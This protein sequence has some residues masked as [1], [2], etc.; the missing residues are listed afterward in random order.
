[1]HVVR[2]TDIAKKFLGIAAMLALLTASTPALAEA[3]S[4]PSTPACCNTAMCPLHRHQGRNAQD[5]SDCAGKSQDAGS[6]MRACDA[7]PD[8]AL[9]IAPYMFVAPFTVFREMTK[10]SAAISLS[11]FF[12]VVVSLPSTPPP[13]TLPS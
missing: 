10:Q 9:E 11:L 12:P 6:S 13:R 3:I 7:S 5:M 8:Q 1:M 4:G 2:L